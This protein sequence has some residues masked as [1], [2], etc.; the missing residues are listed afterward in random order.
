MQTWQEY[1]QINSPSTYHTC[2]L[3]VTAT[4]C[5]HMAN[6]RTCNKTFMPCIRGGFCPE[7]HTRRISWLSTVTPATHTVVLKYPTYGTSKPPTAHVCVDCSRWP[8][9]CSTSWQKDSV[10]NGTWLPV[11]IRQST[12]SR[13][14]YGNS[15]Y[16]LVIGCSRHS[17]L[18]LHPWPI[19][20][21]G[22]N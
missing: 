5:K 7:S 20:H 1:K 14:H 22:G 19:S 15:T 21:A 6:S 11:S 3:S 2:K 9:G 18:F 17:A 12:G 8:W 4:F 10:T 16:N 13:F